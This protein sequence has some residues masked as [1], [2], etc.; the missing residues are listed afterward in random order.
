MGA[1]INKNTFEGD[2]HWKEGAKLN[3]YGRRFQTYS[4]NSI[5]VDQFVSDHLIWLRI[6]GDLLQEFRLY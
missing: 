3:H 1:L 6:L 5:P 4:R 2:A